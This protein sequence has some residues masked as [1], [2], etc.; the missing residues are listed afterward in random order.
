MLWKLAAFILINLLLL[1]SFS[2]SV[3]RLK[4][5]PPEEDFLE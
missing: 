4:D 5:D 1:L 3:S 2:I